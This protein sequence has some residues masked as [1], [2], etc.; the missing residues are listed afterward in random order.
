VINGRP[1]HSG[2]TDDRSK[3]QTSVDS[4]KDEDVTVVATSRILSTTLAQFLPRRVAISRSSFR[5]HSREETNSIFVRWRHSLT[6]LNLY[7]LH[8]IR[9]VI[10]RLSICHRLCHVSLVFWSAI[11]DNALLLSVAILAHG[12]DW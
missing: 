2:L 11:L 1:T 5:N 8:D 4:E 6:F 12:S 3:P 9:R 7:L 10:H